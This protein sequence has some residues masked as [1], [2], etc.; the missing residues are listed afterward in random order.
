MWFT[1]YFHALQ[2]YIDNCLTP[3]A[4]EIQQLQLENF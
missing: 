3:P 2:D 1:K 4:R